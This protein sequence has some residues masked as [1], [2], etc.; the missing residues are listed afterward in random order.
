MTAEGSSSAQALPENDVI[1][2]LVAQHARIRAL[3]AAVSTTQGSARSELFDELRA[4]LAVHETAEEMVLRPTTRRVA[5]D[6]VADARMH[7]ETEASQVLAGLE[8]L[9]PDSDDFD[10]ELAALEKAVW[11]HAEKE[12]NEE[13]P[14]ILAGCDEAERRTMGR[15]LTAAEAVAPTHPHASTAGST[16]KQWAAGPVASIADRTR[17]AIR[18]VRG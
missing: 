5:G 17:D 9:D 15:M 18:R 1:A 14:A 16:A 10:K 6:A 8:R 12:E 3:F 13:F 11:S 2:I 7:E 4:L